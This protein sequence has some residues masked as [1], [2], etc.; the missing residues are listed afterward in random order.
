MKQ[1]ILYKKIGN[2]NVQCLACNWYC[3][4]KDGNTGVCGIRENIK[5]KL[6]LLTYG[7]PFNGLAIDPI[8]KKP[9]FHFLPG[10]KILSFGTV[11]CNFACKFCQNWEMSQYPRLL[12]AETNNKK[13]LTNLLKIEIN[14]EET[15]SP[16]KI[17]EYA[18]LNKIPSIAYTY[19]EP[20]IYFEYA[21]DTAK[22]AYQNGI[23]NVFVSNGYESK[24]ALEMIHS[25]LDAINI[26]LKS[27]SEEFY[28]KTCK[29]KLKPVLDNIRRCYELGIWMEVTTLVIPTLNDSAEELRKC[30]DFLVSLSPSIPW[31]LSAFHPDY[32]VNN[33][34]Q[35]SIAALEEAYK[36]GIS[37]GLKYVYIGNIVD[38]KRDTTYCSKCMEPLLIREWGKI[39]L[40]N[41]QDGNCSKC[42]TKI[43][44]VW[45]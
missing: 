43:E 8:E 2:S 39:D 32:K 5:G 1:A 31:H 21:Y 25:Y 38:N 17:V 16:E 22:L 10:S 3:K 44:G 6:F 19:N 40:F 12:R 9:L 42:K 27:F 20:A 15:W 34:P 26:D 33:L 36:I 30:A 18:V 29:A 41:I 28:M 4:I 11:G 35:T 24:K 13:Q 7:K 45:Q 37:S 14:R 23:K